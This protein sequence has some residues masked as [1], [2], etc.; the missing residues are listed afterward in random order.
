[1]LSR[2]ADHLYWMARYMERAENLV[3]MLDASHRFSLMPQ[4]GAD[5]VEP[6]ASLL[7]IM[8]MSEAFQRRGEPVTP[9]EVL[10]F[11]VFEPENPSSIYS[12]LHSVRESAHAVRGTLT[13]E[14]WEA[15]NATWLVMRD[16]PR[17]GCL[18]NGPGA[19]LD[20]VKERS[21]QSRGV[22]LGTMLNDDALRFMRLGTFLERADNTAR[23]LATKF[24]MLPPDMALAAPAT[25]FY[26][27]SALLHSVS[28]F[29]IYRKVY[30]DLIS[31]MKVA[32]LL[33]LR[34][35]M[36]RSLARCIKDVYDNL[37]VVANRH[38]GE[39][40]RYAGQLD[41][42]LRFARIEDVA[43]NGLPNFLASFLDR[44][45]DLGNR[46]ADDFLVP[47]AR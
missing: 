29:E 26:S 23:I 31:P 20:W 11:M 33:V 47:I 24:R 36:P 15:A 30:R 10:D 44:I 21:H 16:T 42:E 17:R 13:S 22:T 40:E 9:T 3:R 27:W 43:A 19:L 32:D 4:V 39:T 25:D 41:A 14:L 2:T 7:D 6:W 8:G 12:C 46:I 28:A 18:D 5:P 37:R 38:S 34:V 35:D 1:M 45:G